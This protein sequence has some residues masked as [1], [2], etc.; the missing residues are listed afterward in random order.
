MTTILFWLK[1]SH[2]LLWIKKYNLAKQL[3]QNLNKNNKTYNKTYY[4]ENILKLNFLI[5]EMIF[6]V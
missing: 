2:I 3:K 5:P 4:F 6:C 1:Y